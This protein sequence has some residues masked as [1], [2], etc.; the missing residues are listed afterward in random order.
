MEQP[1][2]S[3]SPSQPANPR[4]QQLINDLAQAI[5][6]GSR[7]GRP[8]ASVIHNFYTRLGEAPGL[9]CSIAKAYDD[10]FALV[11]TPAARLGRARKTVIRKAYLT[12]RRAE[13]GLQETLLRPIQESIHLAQ[14][15][16]LRA[17]LEGPDAPRVPEHPA[18]HAPQASIVVLSYNRLDYLKTTLA[19]FHAT[20]GFDDYELI[21]V[22]NGS[23]DGTV[24][25]LREAVERRLCTKVIL[26][27]KNR[28]ISPGYNLG[29]AHA[30]PGTGCFV[31]LDSDIMMLTPR[32]LPRMLQLLRNNVRIG[33]LCTTIV[34][35]AHLRGNTS[36]TL[37]GE[38]LVDWQG[39]VI[40]AAGMCIPAR[41][42]KQLGGFCEEF[43][44]SYHPDDVDYYARLVRAGYD[45]FYVRGLRAY[46]RK[47]L[48]QTKFRTYHESKQADIPRWHTGEQLGR[49]YDRRERPLGLFYPRYEGCR[50][51]EDRRLIEID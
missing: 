44:Y 24:E 21:V 37:G 2:Q 45:G 40:G 25:F 39:W 51:P 20:I 28:G 38:Q 32:W 12:K 1:E 43:D 11:R 34:N 47:D 4:Y 9:G 36:L 8:P 48:D 33:V 35:H 18:G 41:V 42:F 16:A 30:A 23:T 14:L 7:W 31:K 26:C 13:R 29:F 6:V 50:F 17:S 10:V 19:A 46:H 5:L 22:E 15:A 3:S 49:A 27:S